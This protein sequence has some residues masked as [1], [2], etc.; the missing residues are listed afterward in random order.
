MD[1]DFSGDYNDYF[2][3]GND[4]DSGCYDQYA[5][6]LGKVVLLVLAVLVVLVLLGHVSLSMGS[7][8]VSAKWHG[9]CNDSMLTASR[10]SMLTASRDSMLTHAPRDSF[11]TYA[12][13]GAVFGV[14]K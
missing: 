1:T 11:L 3:G 13:E 10:D 12:G 9:S 7:D 2:E 6:M 5:M 4:G 14:D 8:S